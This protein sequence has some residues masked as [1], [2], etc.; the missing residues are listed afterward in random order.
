MIVIIIIGVLASISVPVYRHYMRKGM[1]Q[2]GEA[3]VA[4]LA[5]S[6]NSY[7]EDYKSFYVSG[8]AWT[9]YNSVLDVDAR[10]NRY[11]TAYQVSSANAASWTAQTTAINEARGIT[12]SITG[13]ANAPSVT[14][15]SGF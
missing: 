3:L 10:E 1:A 5:A 6:Q 2:E 9:G 11:F 8:D 13:Y 14:T 15:V 7:W 4:A 12:V